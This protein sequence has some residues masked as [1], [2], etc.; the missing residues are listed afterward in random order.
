VNNAAAKI[1]PG[2]LPIIDT[3]NNKC[4]SRKPLG[5]EGKAR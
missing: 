1:N 4:A 3:A 2:E 5:R